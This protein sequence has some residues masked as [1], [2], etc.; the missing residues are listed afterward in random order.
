MQDSMDTA[1]EPSSSISLRE[2]GDVLRRRRAII[3]Q[4]FVIVLV[5]GV[6]VTLFTAPTYRSTARLLL[7]PVSFQINS[8][9][10]SDPLADLFSINQAYSI[11]TQV[12]LLQTADIRKKVSDAIGRGASLPSMTVAPVEGT[13]IIEVTSEG[14]NPEMVAQAPNELLKIYVKDVG[15]A[16]G[17]KLNAALDFTKK[18]AEHYRTE[19]EKAERALQ[20]FKTSRNVADFD[21]NRADQ[22]KRVEFLKT[23]FSEAQGQM[24]VLEARIAAT[25]AA[26]QSPV[27]TQ[28][29][30]ELL[31]AAADPSV[32]GIQ[33]EIASAKIERDA[34][35]K[36]N[37]GPDNRTLQLIN[38][39]ISRLTERQAELIR[40]SKIRNERK[41]PLSVGLDEQLLKEAGDVKAQAAQVA[42]NGR[43]LSEAQARYAQ[44]PTW[45]SEYAK[46]QRNFEGNAAQYKMF[47]SKVG[48]LDLRAQNTRKTASIMQTAE[49]PSAPIR[50]KKAQNIVMAGMLGLFFGLC[51]AL[52]QEL[53]D[54]RINSPEEAER[55]LRMPNL[56]HIPMI[57]E[58]GLRLI[59]DISAFSPLMES[60][61]SLRTNINFAAVGTPIRSLVVTSSVPAEGKSTTVANLAMAM[62]LDSKRVIIVDADLRRPSQHKLFKIDSSPGLTDLLVGTHTLEEVIRETGVAGV[63]VIPAGSPPPNPAELLGSTAMGHL[64]ATLEASADVVLFDT[65]PALA[66]ADSVVLASRTN[67]VVLVIGYGETKKTNTRKAMEILSRANAHVLGTVLNRMDGPA[68]GYYYGKYYVPATAASLTG[69]GTT[70]NGNGT[71]T[72]GVLPPTTS[73]NSSDDAASSSASKEN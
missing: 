34:Q 8:V 31:S 28:N 54:D 41:N 5:A 68:S 40:L 42:E 44:F 23:S 52:L 64:L 43:Q 58:E 27:A 53:F 26:K 73:S 15:E 25:T 38:Y 36:L 30:T 17:N 19:T 48:D 45:E 59:K 67:G 24:R 46:L 21:Q 2:Y 16:S 63:Q 62:A 56:G 3:L 66:V 7:E 6:L 71:G 47:A 20:K 50:P 32:I 4:T 22:A 13:Q 60:Y 10:G 33:N 37:L 39:R 18:Q 12:E 51:L 14:D 65:P 61:R 72:S 1:S 69:S 11:T 55:V 29:R 49:V 70:R 35:Q 57:E 9:N